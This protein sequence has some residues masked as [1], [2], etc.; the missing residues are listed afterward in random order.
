MKKLVRMFSAEPIFFSRILLVFINNKSKLTK[1]EKII[2]SGQPRFFTFSVED[3]PSEL[4]SW[5][6]LPFGISTEINDYISVEDVKVAAL[7][8]EESTT[9]AK[10]LTSQFDYG[11]MD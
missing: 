5:N 11:E 6:I 7:K 2:F 8:N 3:C 9:S 4:K 10:Y 1:S